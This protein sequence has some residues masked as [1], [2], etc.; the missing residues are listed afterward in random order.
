MRAETVATFVWGM[1]LGAWLAILLMVN[2][3]ARGVYRPDG[4]MMGEVWGPATV[5][6]VCAPAPRCSS[7]EM[8]EAQIC[9]MDVRGGPFS[10]N[11]ANATTSWAHDL[12]VFLGGVASALAAHMVW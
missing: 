5:R 8:T 12:F 7:V 3:C 4:S 9:T 6:I 2:G 11:A 10:T 1:V